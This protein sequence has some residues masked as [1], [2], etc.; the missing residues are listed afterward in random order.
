[1]ELAQIT[2]RVMDNY[3]RYLVEQDRLI[4]DTAPIISEQ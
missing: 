1:M 4:E 3:L 2:W